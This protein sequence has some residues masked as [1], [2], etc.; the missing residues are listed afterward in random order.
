MESKY[1]EIDN[2]LIYMNSFAERLIQ[3]LNE[4]INDCRSIDNASL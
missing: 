2:I 4:A 3:L 1:E